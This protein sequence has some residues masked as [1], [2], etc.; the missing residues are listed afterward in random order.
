MWGIMPS[1]WITSEQK[2]R[3]FNARNNPRPHF[4]AYHAL[5]I[6]LCLIYF[7]ARIIRENDDDI[8][9]NYCLPTYT[10]LEEKSFTARGDIKSALNFLRDR[11][12]INYSRRGHRNY[13]QI[14][15][16]KKRGWAKVPDLIFDNKSL[17]LLAL[18]PSSV[19]QTRRFYISLDALKIYFLFLA[20]RQQIDNRA[21]GIHYHYITNHTGV[22]RNNI[23]Q[24]ISL[25]AEADLITSENSYVP[26]L[27]A[28][29][30]YQVGTNVY[31]INHLRQYHANR[32]LI[33]RDWAQA[34]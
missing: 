24:A 1:Y 12:L 27:E 28:E 9:I 33:P 15:G 13:Y 6:Y 17:Q 11:G 8:A 19:E 31:F 16:D 3:E 26:D 14:L 10:E 7:N 23:K 22:Q 18:R 2:L 25:L 29:G 30:E 20:F 21:R 5:K 34:R 32:N 4:P